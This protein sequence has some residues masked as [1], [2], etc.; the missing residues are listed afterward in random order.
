ML[1]ICNS[2]IAASR[3]WISPANLLA[4]HLLCRTWFGNN[5]VQNCLHWILFSVVYITTISYEASIFL[6]FQ[7]STVSY[8]AQNWR[9]SGVRTSTPTH[10]I[11]EYLWFLSVNIKEIGTCIVGIL[12]IE[13][14]QCCYRDWHVFQFAAGLRHLQANEN[15]IWSLYERLLWKYS[16]TLNSEMM[17]AWKTFLRNNCFMRQYRIT[18][19]L[20]IQDHRFIHNP[21][22]DVQFTNSLHK[23][24]SHLQSGGN[25]FDPSLQ[26]CV[27]WSSK[28]TLSQHD[29]PRRPSDS[30]RSLL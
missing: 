18:D 3:K 27:R 15:H 11:M 6:K 17:M 16:S 1:L 13:D 4:R 7:L 10:S 14:V 29:N 26:P 9:T 22:L 21:R 23:N 28:S 2:K 5:Y 12:N 8:P 25:G 24:I 30:L 19:L 20:A